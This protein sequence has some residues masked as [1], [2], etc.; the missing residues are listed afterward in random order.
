MTRNN[1]KRG[2]T[3]TY[4]RQVMFKGTETVTAKIV[5]IGRT[6]ILLDNGDEITVY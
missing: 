3:I 2:Q 1:F 6:T 5:A 4:T